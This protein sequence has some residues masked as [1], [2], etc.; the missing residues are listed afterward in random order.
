[1]FCELKSKSAWSYRFSYGFLL[2][3]LTANSGCHVVFPGQLADGP[4]PCVPCEIPREQ[5]KVTLPDYII[6][7]PDI[8]TIEAISLVPKAPYKLRPLDAVSI[9]SVGLPEEEAIAGEYTLQPNGRIQ[10]GHSFGSIQAAGQTTEELQENIL[11][12]LRLQ[13]KDPNVWVSLLSMGAQQQVTGEHL[14]APDGK[15]NLGTYGRVRVVGL[16]IE[17]AQAAVQSHLSEYLESPEIAL[18]VLGYNSKVFYVITQGAGLGD[19][20]IILPARGNETVLDAI[21]QI[22]GLQSNSSTRMWI[23]RPGYNNCGGDQILPVDWLAVTQ[24]GDIKTNYQ[25]LPGDRVYVSEDKLVAL[26]TTLG[27]IMSP[28]ERLFGVTLLGTQTAQRLVFFGDGLGGF[29]GF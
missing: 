17:E 10:L 3:L 7:P 27:K 6:E 24:R 26:D 23:A 9:F 12:S 8:L 18:D 22:Q 21:G 15:V 4:K 19:Q 14:V 13:Y 20:V 1:V 29:G 11:T 16:T 5:A 28:L 25:V 2:L